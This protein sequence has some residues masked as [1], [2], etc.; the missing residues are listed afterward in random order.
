MV[1]NICNIGHNSVVCIRIMCL[2]SGVNIRN[3]PKP[4][5]G[6]LEN[7]MG[8]VKQKLRFA[9]SAGFYLA[10]GLYVVQNGLRIEAP[11]NKY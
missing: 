6:N 7:F 10:N 5:K 2:V 8:Y 9:T 3:V 4:D 1:V 11:K